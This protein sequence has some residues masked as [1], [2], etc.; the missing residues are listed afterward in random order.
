MDGLDRSYLV[1]Q[2]RRAR[3]LTQVQLAKLARTSQATLSAYERGLKSPSLKVASRILAATDH[4]LTLRTW[5]DWVQHH[6]EGIVAF[7]AP[8][9]LWAVPPPMC[10]ATILMPD[11]IRPPSEDMRME[12]DLGIREER[13][14]AY[15]QLIRRGLP[16]QMMRWIDGGLLVDVWTELDLPAPVRAAWAQAIELATRPVVDDGLRFMFGKDPETAATARVRGYQPLPKPPPSVPR[17]PR[18]TRFDRHP[19]PPQRQAGSRDDDDA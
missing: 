2:A 16:Q 13:V 8:S 10:F 1:E 7:W 6:P 11:Q 17:R 19:L 5:V 9:M 18:R 15:E 4:E 12:W 3:G 14:G